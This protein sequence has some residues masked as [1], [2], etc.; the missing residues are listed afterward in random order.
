MYFFVSAPRTCT[1]VNS[2]TNS[3]TFSWQPATTA[4][5]YELFNVDRT[6]DKTI[7]ET[8]IT[9]TGLTAGSRY[10]FTVSAVNVKELLVFSITC[11][12]TTGRPI[13]IGLLKFVKTHTR[14]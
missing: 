4:T 5:K 3:L 6:V 7:T 9:V 1:F 14:C 10:T 13:G 8:T 11:V 2:T 12:N